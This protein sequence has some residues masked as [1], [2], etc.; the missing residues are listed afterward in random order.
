MVQVVCYRRPFAPLSLHFGTFEFEFDSFITF[1][2]S[3][4]GKK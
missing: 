2:L 1:G 3:P 4:V